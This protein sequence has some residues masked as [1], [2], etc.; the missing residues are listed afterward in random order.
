VWVDLTTNWKELG[1]EKTI[2]GTGAMAKAQATTL[3]FVTNTV[4]ARQWRKELIERM[5]VRAE[6]IGEYRANAKTSSRSPSPHTRC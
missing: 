5:S 3:T 2:V 1:A 6:D 4:S